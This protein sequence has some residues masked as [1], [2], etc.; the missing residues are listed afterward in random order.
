M[1]ENNR[2][3]FLHLSQLPDSPVKKYTASS[4]DMLC[5]WGN[6]SAPFADQEDVLAFLLYSKG[7]LH[8]IPD[9]AI[10]SAV[11]KSCEHAGVLVVQKMA[12]QRPPAWIVGIECDS[13]GRLRWDQH[14][15]AYRAG[16]ATFTNSHNLKRVPVQMD[17]VSHLSSV[18]QNEFNAFTVY[19]RKRR[20]LGAPCYVIYR[21]SI[22]FHRAGQVQTV[23]AVGCARLQ[24]RGRE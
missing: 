3:F 4:S 14:R 19:N 20:N 17:R 5:S 2:L 13:H 1:I 21:P 6:R 12:V 11:A 23:A 16:K 9:A 7:K 22:A 10:R 24:R 18:Y 15:V 8:G